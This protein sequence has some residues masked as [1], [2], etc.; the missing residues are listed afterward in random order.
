MTG[1]PAPLRSPA[2]LADAFE[3]GLLALLEEEG[4]GALILVCANATF[5]PQLWRRFEGRLRGRFEEAAARHR[6]T[7]AAGRPPAVP[8]EDLLVFLK[9]ALIG[10]DG[11]RL[12][13]TRRAGP[14]R[15]QFNQLRSLRPAR[16]GGRA[17]TATRAPF[18]PAGFHFDRPFLKKETFWAGEL[19]GR[20]VALLYNKYPF[21]RFH[22]LLVPEQASGLPQY[23]T[24]DH[25]HW[26]WRAVAALG[27]A[28][29]GIGVGYNGYGA[30]ASVN[31]LHFHLF[32]E[33]D[34]LPVEEGQW[35]HNGGDRPY[36]LA[37]RRCDDAAAAWAEIDALQRREIA[38]NL[39][40]LPGR[41]LLLPRRRQGEAALP[42][43]S[44]GFAWSELAGSVVTFN[45]DDYLAL[46]EAAITAEL[47]RL[48]VGRAD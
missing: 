30:Y 46:D 24:A 41:L 19:E 48:A 37:C 38:C 2:A 29:P 20:P 18:D 42:A 16:V 12:T 22:G 26:L 13:E 43:W 47:A 35:R 45:R 27:A 21:A 15:V 34:G 14:W 11:F 32:V 5:E 31:H 25:H 33:P 1:L 10:F 28:L 40:Y 4:L 7:L 36:P 3:A 6:A 8:E 17:V 9:L 23:L 44:A 39:I